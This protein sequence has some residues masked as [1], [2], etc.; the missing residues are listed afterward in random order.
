MTLQ[1]FNTSKLFCLTMTLVM[2]LGIF[3]S[4]GTN[5]YAAENNEA[6]LAQLEKATG[7]AIFYDEENARFFID[8]SIAKEQN[9]TEVQINNLKEW[10]NYINNDE[11]VLNETL[12]FG[13]Y[14]FTDSPIQPRVLPAFLIIALKAIGVGALTAVSGA[15]AKWGMKGACNKMGGNYA[16]FKSFCEANGWHVGY[17]FGGGGRDF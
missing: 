17:G 2:I 15:V 16:P 1:G 12:K 9:L 7:E 13:G 8:E 3:I 11:N 6:D 5:V 14:D 10:I 4:A